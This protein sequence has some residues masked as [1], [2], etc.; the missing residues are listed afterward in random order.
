MPSEN[1]ESIEHLG[2]SALRRVCAQRDPSVYLNKG[3]L[4]CKWKFR[5]RRAANATLL[6]G[7]MH[8]AKRAHGR[9]LRSVQD[10]G[11]H[12]HRCAV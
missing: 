11:R 4:S 5:L 1:G 3:L 9:K 7:G 6:V 12:L 10:C 2:N 8:R